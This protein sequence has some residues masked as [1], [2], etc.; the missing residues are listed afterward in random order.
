MSPATAPPSTRLATCAVI[1]TAAL[2]ILA[3][4]V[5]ANRLVAIDTSEILATRQLASP[6]LTAV[7]LAASHSAGGW[8]V[9]VLA[10]ILCG[11]IYRLGSKQ[12][13]ALYAVAC[14]G[15]E[16]LL[17]TL[18]AV[19]RHH[20]PV[21]ISPKLTDA[22]WYSF[23]SGHSMLGVIIFGLGALLVTRRA[24]AAVRAAAMSAAIVVIALVAISRVYLG[25]HWPSD[26]VGALLAGTAW[27][28]ACLA[29]S[30]RRTARQA[31]TAST[32]GHNPYKAA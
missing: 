17:L 32:D 11:L 23:P 24:S 19:I 9:V 3:G 8:V 26:V 21:G 13:A 10:L 5:V 20:R 2:A 7:M 1:C 28:T 31:R 30:A 15:G 14:L 16:L 25:A 18:K 22:G 12:D 6:A 27:T 29:W 4:F